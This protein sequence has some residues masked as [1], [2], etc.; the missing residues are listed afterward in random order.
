VFEDPRATT[1]DPAGSRYSTQEWLDAIEQA[2]EVALATSLSSAGGSSSTSAGGNP[3]PSS[4]HS[5]HNPH[6]PYH[7]GSPAHM[8]EGFDSGAT[9]DSNPPQQHYQHRHVL[10]QTLRRTNT[11]E[12]D[13]GGGGSGDGGGNGNSAVAGAFATGRKRFS[14]RH[15][16]S[17]LAAV[18]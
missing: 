16:K 14:K 2:R 3:F 12:Y 9:L 10:K 5:S 18:F 7:N 17:G 11:D 15:S 8:G 4:A 13:E 6:G 1:S